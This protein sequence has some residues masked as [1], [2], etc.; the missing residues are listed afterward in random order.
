MCDSD[1][2]CME[3]WDKINA[4]DDLQPLILAVKLS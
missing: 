3:C 2:E 1:C 4:K